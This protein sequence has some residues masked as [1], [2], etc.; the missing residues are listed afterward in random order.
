MFI[1]YKKLAKELNYGKFKEE[2]VNKVADIIANKIIDNGITENILD[3]LTIKIERYDNRFGH[4]G[5][6]YDVKP[7]NEFIAEK[8][9]NRLIPDVYDLQKAEVLRDVHKEGVLN[10]LHSKLEEQA[11]QHVLDFINPPL[12][13]K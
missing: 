11:K 3:K 9:A 6:D 10:I 2:V 4:N 8:V 12:K 7:L 5:Y 13:W 1:N